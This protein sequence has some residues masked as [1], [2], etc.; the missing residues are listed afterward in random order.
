MGATLTTNNTEP[1]RPSSR[2]RAAE[3]R[4]RILNKA[5]ELI[6]TRSIHHV[7]LQDVAK[8]AGV[9]SA[10]AVRYFKS[11]E[12]LFLEAMFAR[13]EA[14]GVPLLQTW[15]DA[16]PEPSVRDVALAVLQRDISIRR[17]T[18]DFMS[19]SYWW[20][21]E[22]ETRYERC[23]EPRRL[24]FE[25]AITL[26]TGLS[27]KAPEVVELIGLIKHVLTSILREASVRDWTEM[28]AADHFM[29]AMTPAFRAA[30]VKTL[31]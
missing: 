15:L 9:S 6:G 25:K 30:G 2:A 29:K 31:D 27:P 14:F 28:Q 4:A 11:K 12:D 23:L 26:A 5:I 1:D 22:D 8:A 17:T 3:T 20:S 21:L 13:W 10:L 24:A 7:Q 16:H 19:M 18:R